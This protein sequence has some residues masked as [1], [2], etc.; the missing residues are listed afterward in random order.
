[1]PSR[2]TRA[3]RPARVGRVPRAL[4]AAF[5]LLAAAAGCSGSSS[6]DDR[7]STTVEAEAAGTTT[8]TVAAPSADGIPTGT[9]TRSLP[10]APALPE[11]GANAP[12]PVSIEIDALDVP[13]APVVAVGV[14][15]EHRCERLVARSAL[16][17]TSDIRWD[18]AP[19]VELD[20]DALHCLVYMRDVEGFTTR[21]LSGLAAHPSTLGDPLVSRFLEAWR[22]EENEHARA[23]DRFLVA[24]CAG[25]GR[26]VPVMQVAPGATPPLSERLIV[27]LTRPVGHVVTAA[28]MT[29]GAMNELLTVNG[30]RMLAER[31][32]H[33]V[34]DRLLSRIAAQEARHYSFY[35][36]QAEWRLQA[37]RVARRVLPALIR[38]TWTP[39]GVGGEYKQPI[40]LD[41]VLAYLAGGANGTQALGVM[42]RT[43]AR[44]PGFAG[45]TPFTIAAQGSLERCG[46]LAPGPGP[47]LASAA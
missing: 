43:V 15:A 11:V 19:T 44:L 14:E 38:K 18:D 42:D 20:D 3:T 7:A 25:R 33:P 17:D 28:H 10:P 34:L 32:L 40:E 23:L 13:G 24:Y 5:I 27:G 2:P 12:A 9:G 35:L 26:D 6:A 29:W 1:V 4:A 47:A 22:A 41:R 45:V 46:A 39:V 31:C 37:S 30:Y 8:S 36:L 21:D 16:L